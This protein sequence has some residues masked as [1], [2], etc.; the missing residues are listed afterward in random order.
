MS[1]AAHPRSRGENPPVDDGD[2]GEGGSSPLTRGKRRPPRLRRRHFGLIPAHAGKTP[3]WIR[4]VMSRPAHPRSR[5]ENRRGISV[6]KRGTG[7]SPLTRGKRYRVLCGCGRCRLIPAHAGKTCPPSDGWGWGPAHPRSRGENSRTAT[8]ARSR[9]GSSPLTRGKR[10]RPST[11]QS[12]GRL[13]PAHAGKT[14]SAGRR[15]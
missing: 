5:G 8:P 14:W 12:V 13:I 3:A 1:A 7:S 11:H 9:S 4:T 10:R 15:S 2:R 6:S